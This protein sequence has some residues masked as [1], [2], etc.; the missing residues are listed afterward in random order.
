M[1]FREIVEN[2]SA[3]AS[4][5]G[6]IAPVES[7]LG[8][9]I[10]RNGGSLLSGKYS[11]ELTPNTPKEYQRNK[12]LADALKTLLAT[13]YAFVIKAQLF[14]WNVEGPDFAQMHEFFGNI[15][16]EV[17]EN[18]IDQTAEFIR[19]L[20]DY[21]PGS[22]ERFGE[23]SVISG[24]TKIP[25]ARLMIEEL[26]ANNQQMIEL[27]N[28]TFS[29]AEQENQQGIMDFLAARIDAHGKHGWMLRSFLKDNRA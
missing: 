24:Q 18:S 6:G 9:P 13:E 3:G 25:R 4:C 22:F 10:S 12:M 2:A 15:Y 27:L 8:A 7:A 23:L 5:A 11:K 14:H 29:A 17:Y 28:N 21:A 20:D 1:R 16:E 19:I 26:Y